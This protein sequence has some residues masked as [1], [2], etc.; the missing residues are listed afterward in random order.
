MVSY[1][2]YKFAVMIELS[3]Y[4]LMEEN[5]EFYFSETDSFG[6]AEGFHLAAGIMTLEGGT[7]GVEVPPEIGSLKMYRKVWNT[8]DDTNGKL[9]FKPIETR[10]CSKD[11]FNDL[12][13][14]NSKSRFYKSRN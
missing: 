13:G 1:G 9:Y 8:F 6:S 4:R 14:S 11:D 7:N 2:C 10:Q 12:E 5:Q 3:N